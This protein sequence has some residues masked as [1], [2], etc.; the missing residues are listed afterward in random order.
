[1]RNNEKDA[2]SNTEKPFQAS[3]ARKGFSWHQD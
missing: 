3:L 2:Y 1:M